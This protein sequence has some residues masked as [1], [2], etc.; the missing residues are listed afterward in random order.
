[1]GR[2]LQGSYQLF[3]HPS[4]P[5][6]CRLLSFHAGAVLSA[7][8]YAADVRGVKNLPA[9]GGILPFTGPWGLTAAATRW[10]AAEAVWVDSEAKVRLPVEL[11]SDEEVVR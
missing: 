8:V 7:G 6:L 5:H 9:G 11:I 3:S 2:R 1:M 10:S 4:L